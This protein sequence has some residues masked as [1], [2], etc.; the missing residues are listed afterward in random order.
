MRYR[1]FCVLL[2]ALLVGKIAGAQNQTN[3]TA[4]HEVVFIC[5]HGAA[6]SLVSAT[7]FNKLAKEQQLGLHAVAR[8]ATPQEGLSLQATAGLMQDGLAPEIQKPLGLSLAEL[9][10]AYRVVTFFPIPTEYALKTP[11]ENWSDVTWGPGSYEKSRDAILTH[12]QEL[13]VRLKS[14]M[15]KP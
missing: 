5:E 4:Q 1:S 8:G 10:E 6:L 2:L 15:K 9:G 3:D 12:I 7:Y 11:A 13:L 14:E